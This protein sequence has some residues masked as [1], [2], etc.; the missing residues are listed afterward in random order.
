MTEPR[1]L[2][3]NDCAFVA[4][5][6]VREAHKAGFHWRHLR[7]DQV[8]PKAGQSRLA[9]VPSEV[10]RAAGLAWAEVAHVHYATS[11]PLIRS[12]F[13]PRRPY[14]LHIPGTD[15]REQYDDPRFHKVIAR[16][17]DEAEAVFYTD[18]DNAAKATSVRSDAVRMPPFVNFDA[19]PERRETEHAP[20]RFA[21]RWDSSKR[22]DVVLEFVRAMRELA[23]AVP[24]EGLDWGP[25]A[26]EAESLGVKLYPKMPHADYV[27]WLAG[28]R[29][30]VGQAAGILAVSELEAMAMGVPLLIPTPDLWAQPDGSR[31]PVLSGTPAEVAEAVAEIAGGDGNLEVFSGAPEWVRSHHS[32]EPWVPYLQEIYRRVARA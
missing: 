30:V 11:V 16:A 29:A 15:I 25:S 2:H 26:A 3:V 10:R 14:L 9:W 4:A 5:N 23:P 12:R 28:A 22:V 8:R 20:I 7:P 21:S 27:S 6:L 13:T 19:L 24:L 1:V 31:P 18:L 32:A 17:I